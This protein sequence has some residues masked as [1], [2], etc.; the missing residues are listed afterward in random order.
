MFKESE[1]LAKVESASNRIH[2]NVMSDGYKEETDNHV[3]SFPPELKRWSV[4]NGIA[5]RPCGDTVE[6]LPPGIYETHIDNNGPFLV[7]IEQT[8]EKIILLPDNP[9]PRIIEDIEKF[10]DRYSIFT[11]YGLNHKRGILLWGPPG[12]G[13][14]C[15]VKLLIK[16]IVSRGGIALLGDNPELIKSLHKVIRHIQPNTPILVIME[17]LDEM[18]RRSNEHELLDLLD[19]HQNTHRTV[20]IATTNHPERL[21]SRIVNRPS[22]FDLVVKVPNPSDNDRRVYLEYLA[23]KS[24]HEVRPSPNTIKKWIAESDGL[25]IA[26]LRELYIGVVILGNSTEDTLERLRF[27][28]DKYPDSVDDYRETIGFGYK[29]TPTPCKIAAR[30]ES[31]W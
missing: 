28:Q 6:I 17:D 16:D 23:S 24:S 15:T 20:F 26:H 14:T 2:A 8:T 31:G 10:W 7:R 3:P 18:I 19:G 9:A 30:P 27:M 11:Q 12:G 5:F 1:L 25:S 4:N 22:R 13:K 29:P 21:G